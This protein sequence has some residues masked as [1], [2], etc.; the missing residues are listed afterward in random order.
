MCGSRVP[1]RFRLGP[2][3]TRIRTTAI[4]GRPPVATG[5]WWCRGSSPARIRRVCWQTG[6]MRHVVLVGLMGSGKTT[7]GRVVAARLGWPL[8]D[9]DVDIEART[10]RTVREIDQQDGT[11]AMH[12]LEATVLLEALA[13]GDPSVICAASSIADVDAC[14]DALRDPSL[15][16]AW[17]RVPVAVA[18]ERF[19]RQGHRPRFGDDPAT[20]LAELAARREPRLATLGA[21]ELD[22]G[23]GTPDSLAD[24]II[25]AADARG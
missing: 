23:T 24:Q 12:A 7:V 17:L 8:R 19:S 4:S 22:A 21:L 5:P 9:S 16:V 3:R 6:A 13:A 25:A 20:F 18:A 14:L 1:T 11:A 15:L 2:S 10:G